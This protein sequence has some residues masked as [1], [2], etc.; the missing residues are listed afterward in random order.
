MIKQIHGRPVGRR[1]LPIFLFVCTFFLLWDRYGQIYPTAMIGTVR[2][3]PSSYDASNAKVYFPVDDFKRPPV[4]VPKSF[5][6]IQAPRTASA[7]PAANVSHARKQIIKSKIIKSWQAYKTYAWSKDELMPLSGRGRQTIGGWSAQIVDAL[8]IL[9][10]LD[11]KDDF[12]RAVERVAVIDWAAGKGSN[13]DLFEVNIRYLGGLLGAYELSGEPVLLIKAIELGDVIY[14][15]FDT[16]N[17]LPAR[18]LDLRR[19]KKGTQISSHDMPIATAGTFS[20]ELTRL[21]QLTGDPKYYDAAE[22]VKSFFHRFQ[23]ETAIPG[24]WPRTVNCRDETINGN[25]YTLGPGA[26]SMYE[27]LPKMHALLGGLDHEYEQMTVHALDAARDHVLFRPMTANQEDIL[28]AGNAVTTN[29]KITTIPETHHLTCYI[30]GMYGLAG[31]LLSR[32]DYLDLGFRLAAGCV[33][34]YDAFASNIMPEIVQLVACTTLTG[35]CERAAETLPAGRRT[36]GFAAL[37]DGFTRVRDKRYHLRPE[38]IESVFYMW[39]ITGDEVWRDA[40]WRMWEGIARE[41]ET[42]LAFASIEDVT[43]QASSKVDVMDTFWLSETLKYLYLIFEDE[44][45][46]SLDEWVFNTEAHPI[47]R[48][49]G[50]R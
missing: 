21:T 17:R 45:V 42:E 26:D 16:P 13:I 3:R 8:D 12:R 36:R 9:W 48:A 18:W 34:A 33:W 6:T 15:A 28:L 43:V 25:L 50:T 35:P 41:T 32:D 37:P 14:S 29:G 44:S 11:L 47:R 10:I 1:L 19:A 40:A 49:R 27:Y 46:L 24:L 31:K 4:G 38:A 22:R 2:Y 7:G 23:N 30:G 39:R 20:L 5:P